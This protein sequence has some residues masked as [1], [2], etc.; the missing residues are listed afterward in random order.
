[1]SNTENTDTAAAI[2][3]LNSKRYVR[4]SEKLAERSSEVADQIHTKMC[5]LGIDSLKVKNVGTLIYGSHSTNQGHYY[6]LRWES[7]EW[8]FA[9]G[10]LMLNK[11]GSNGDGLQVFGDA[12]SFVLYP[13]LD[14]VL[15]FA[16]N[17]T[18]IFEALEVVDKNQT[19]K[20]QAALDILNN[21]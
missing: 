1:M 13:T 15:R 7:E 19:E 17:I 16:M 5:H 11:V 18:A 14:E 12:C 6:T 10:D 21:Q 8:G 3:T 20:C 2:K 4:V 9:A